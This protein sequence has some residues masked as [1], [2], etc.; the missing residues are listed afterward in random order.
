MKPQSNL[1]NQLIFFLSQKCICS[2]EILMM[3]HILKMVIHILYI[4]SKYNEKSVSVSVC[5]N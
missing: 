5:L 3:H 1:I 4:V 2:E